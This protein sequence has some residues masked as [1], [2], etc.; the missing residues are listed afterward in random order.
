MR[1]RSREGVSIGLERIRREV[2]L[3]VSRVEAWAAISDP[4]RLAAWFGAEV[5]LQAR[6]GG[7][8][9]FRW[10]SGVERGAIVEEVEPLCSLAFRW[11]AFERWPDGTILGRATTRVELSLE[12]VESG[13]R[14]TV[15]ESGFPSLVAA[16]WGVP[17]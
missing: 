6:P 16:T 17:A 14:L 5:E 15:V 12:D 10:P 3:P 1:L 2:I 7:R 4:G 13:T 9:T 8:G 11:V